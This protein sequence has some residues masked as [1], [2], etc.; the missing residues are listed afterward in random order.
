M[1]FG[2]NRL[3]SRVLN[4]FLL[5]EFLFIGRELSLKFLKFV[6]CFLELLNLRI[7]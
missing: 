3:L 5:E 2:K 4:D 1:G 6:K 7:N